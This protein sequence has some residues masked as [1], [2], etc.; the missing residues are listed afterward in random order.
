MIPGV[1]LLVS[2]FL[3]FG[4]D[5]LNM[6][7]LWGELG[8]IGFLAWEVKKRINDIPALAFF[9]FAASAVAFAYNSHTQFQAPGLDL[10][11]MLSSEAAKS[12][13]FFM[14]VTMP[15][16]FI[17]RK[18]LY[19]WREALLIFGE[20]NA[21]CMIFN[22]IFFSN[23]IG[24]IGMDSIDATFLAI[25]LP[26]AFFHPRVKR[27]ASILFLMAIVI[28]K[29]S[30]AYGVVALELVAWV[31]FYYCQDL[32]ERICIGGFSAFALAGIG[33][34]YLGSELLNDNGR[35]GILVKSYNFFQ[36]YRPGEVL[37]WFSGI[38]P[39]S[40]YN[41]MPFAQRPA[42]MFFIFAHNEP[43]QV[44]WEQG[45]TGLALLLSVFGIGLYK[46]RKSKPIFLALLGAG[47]SCFFQ[48]C[49]RYFIL[50]LL[51]SF[52]CRISYENEPQLF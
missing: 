50:A 25:L 34:I 4:P 3:A 1:I 38:G 14:L 15:F 27:E 23:A 44:M 28:A 19:H 8:V 20:I 11:T 24:M 22:K 40:F 46:S 31:F 36:E 12:A 51:M 35:L 37:K 18:G 30:T 49:F 39:G 32:F 41:L 29:S 7:I 5:H 47:F 45:A 42:S 33:K 10:A 9:Y 6:Q 52:L 17:E 21:L 2:A 43:A 26:I 16:I 13:M 48:P